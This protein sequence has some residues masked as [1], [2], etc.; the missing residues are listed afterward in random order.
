LIFAFYYRDFL[1]VTFDQE[2]ARAMSLPL[3]KL[4]AIFFFLLAAVISVATRTIGG[5][6]VFAFLILPAMGALICAKTTAGVIG[7]AIFFGGISA[8]VGYG[9]SFIFELPTGACMA[10]TAGLCVAIGYGTARFRC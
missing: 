7:L 10:V 4:N 2:A 6:P 8:F 5:M 1:F 3:R 9:A